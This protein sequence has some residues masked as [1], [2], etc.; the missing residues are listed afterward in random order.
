M[1]KIRDFCTK[2]II[3]LTP[4][5][6]IK[7]V[8]DEFLKSKMDIGCVFHSS[9]RLEGIISKNA[10]FRAMISGANI[11]SSIRPYIRKKIVTI[12]ESDSMSRA[13]D[14]MLQEKV[15]HGVVL[16]KKKEVLG[17]VSKADIIRGFLNEQEILVSQLSDLIAHLEDAVVSVDSEGT[18][19]TV[20]LALE[21][22]LGVNKS[23]ILGRKIQ[24]CIPEISADL[25]FAL[26][27]QQI[28][29]LQRIQIG[30]KSIISSYIPISNNDKNNGAIAVLQDI[31]NLEYYATEL[32]YT[33]NLQQTLN[34]ALSLSYDAIAIIDKDGYITEAN[35]AFLKLFHANR[36]LIGQ[37][38]SHNIGE[39]QIDEVLSGK[40]IE[41]DV[42]MIA[43]KAC[44]IY[45]E[46][47]LRSEQIHG[48]I[49]KIIFRQLDEWKDIIRRLEILENEVTY[50]KGELKKATLQSNTFDRIISRNKEVE[51]IKRHAFLSADSVSTVLITGE[52]GTGKELFAEAIHMESKRTGE[53]VKVNCAAIPSELLESEFFGYSEGAF[54]GAKKGGKKGKFELA[55]RGT[56]FLDEIGDMPLSLQ[57][58]I[59]RVLQEKS[60]ERIG[61]VKT[62][63]V[64]VRIVAATHRNLK[65]MVLDGTFREDLY[66]RIDVVSFYIPPLRDRLDD[67]PLLCDHLIKKLNK[68]LN[69]N[70]YGITPETLIM[71]ENYHWP[72]NIRQLENVLE[73]AMHMGVERWIEP[74]HLPDQL[75]Q[76]SKIKFVSPLEDPESREQHSLDDIERQAIIDILRKTNFNRSDAAK[77]LG[78][79]RSGLYK[80]LKKYQIRTEVQ[81][82]S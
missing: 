34:H 64:D 59:L 56:L 68:K 41:G 61:D 52:S 19:V 33:K 32:E 80:K 55:D 49:T 13:R 42:R 45:Q 7:D 14:I 2:D 51:K 30:D 50:Y 78:I 47:L 38:W 25:Y 76:K 28:R 69:K 79:S 39:L 37:Y 6:S 35:D 10:I 66:Y 15:A 21:K 17:V 65:Q 18:V 67:L 26:S 44:I 54:T 43:G 9:G 75:T 62:Q 5:N 57:A 74:H 40:R 60:F 58:K 70:I 72:G 48:A 29:K 1:L 77:Q 82:N 3:R 24:H 46:P 22:M 81:F 4:S 11:D 71:M 23:Q 31:T 27:T 53:F 8:L 12:D 73:R 63:Q 36:E 16:N 20:N